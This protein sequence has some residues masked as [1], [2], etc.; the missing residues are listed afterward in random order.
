MAWISMLPKLADADTD[1]ERVN[2]RIQVAQA[3]IGNVKVASF[4]RP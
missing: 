1:F 3:S 4:N 2:S